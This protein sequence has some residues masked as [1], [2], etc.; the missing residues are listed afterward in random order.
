[1]QI[2]GRQ[3]SP[4]ATVYAILLLIVSCLFTS[5]S[6][7]AIIIYGVS[8]SGNKWAGLFVLLSAESNF[9]SVLTITDI[10]MNQCHVINTLSC[11]NISP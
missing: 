5:G 7:V 10:R 1:M 6:K 11:A 3:N 4:K 2:L 9:T 8:S